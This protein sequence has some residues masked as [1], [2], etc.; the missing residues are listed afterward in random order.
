MA[1]VFVGGEIGRG[2]RDG[3][4]A[5]RVEWVR[6]HVGNH[7]HVEDEH[8]GGELVHSHSPK[9]ARSLKVCQNREKLWHTWSSP[10]QGT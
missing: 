5:G 9:R 8:V 2:A 7:N 1:T 10:P 3:V 4:R 6:V